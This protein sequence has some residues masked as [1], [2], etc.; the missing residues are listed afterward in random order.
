MTDP[1]QEKTRRMGAEMLS[2]GI[3]LRTGKC[4][5]LRFAEPE[6]QGFL[7]IEGRDAGGFPMA[8]ADYLVTLPS[9]EQRRGTL[10]EQGCARLEGVPAGACTVRFPAP[11]LPPAPQDWP[12]RLSNPRWI[13]LETG[14]GVLAARS[15]QTLGLRVDIERPG[16]STRVQLSIM[17]K[18][19]DGKDDPVATV[20]GTVCQ[21][22]VQAEWAYKHVSDADEEGTDKA[23][24]K[25]EVYFVCTI[26]EATVRS[27]ILEFADFVEIRGLDP[28]GQPLAHAAFRLH[29]ADGNERKGEL[30]AEGCARVERVP[31]GKV[32]VVFLD[33]T[34]PP[35]PAEQAA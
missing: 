12:A 33:Q 14:V 25:P 26:G 27:P 30:D 21:G 4:H 20:E 5:K 18:D 13:D 23:Y 3:R 34:L 11:E 15:G 28:Q 29:L 7:A 8:F 19:A 35:M 16:A 2:S 9:G 22:Q 17:E 24:T 32:T 1:Q 31:P 6:Q 10:D